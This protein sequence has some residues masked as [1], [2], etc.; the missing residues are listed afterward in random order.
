M[1]ADRDAD[2]RVVDDSEAYLQLVP[3]DEYFGQD[4]MPYATTDTESGAIEFSFD[5]AVDTVGGD[6]VATDSVYEFFGRPA[7]DGADSAYTSMFVAKNRGSND[8]ILYQPGDVEASPT[9]RIVVEELDWNGELT[10][11]IND[12]VEDQSVYV[13]SGEAVGLGM[14]IDTTD[15]DNPFENTVDLSVRAEEYEN[16]GIGGESVG[17]ASDQAPGPARTE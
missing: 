17:S 7:S 2:V 8:I 1:N 10:G 4:W 16:D 14:R 5:D 3:T 12:L 11:E 13:P 9:V 15:V 6:G